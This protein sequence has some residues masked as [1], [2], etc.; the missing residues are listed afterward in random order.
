MHQIGGSAYK[1]RHVLAMADK[2][3]RELFSTEVW[4]V[5][6]VENVFPFFEGLPLRSAASSVGDFGSFVE[7]KSPL[8]PTETGIRLAF[9]QNVAHS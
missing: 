9:M 2:L 8:A 5:A 7:N 3:Y 6:E 1:S 4:N